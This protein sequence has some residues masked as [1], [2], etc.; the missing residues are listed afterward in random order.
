M[1][2]QDTMENEN[3]VV[4]MMTTVDN[5]YDPIDDY[6]HWLDFDMIKGYGTN[7]LLSR[8]TDIKYD[9]MSDNEIKNEIEKAIDR[10]ISEDPLNLYKKVK[11]APS[12]FAA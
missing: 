12:E 4:V 2:G 5:P 6:D 11:H 10:F 7:E 8:I 9:E 1:K 3:D